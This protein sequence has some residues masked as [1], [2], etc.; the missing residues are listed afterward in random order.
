MCSPSIFTNVLPPTLA[1]LAPPNTLPLRSPE[2]ISTEVLPPRSPAFPPP[3]TLPPILI[4]PCTDTDSN[5]SIRAKLALTRVL[6]IYIGIDIFILS[7][8]FYRRVV[9]ISIRQLIDIGGGDIER[10][11]QFV[12]TLYRKQRS[13]QGIDRCPLT[14]IFVCFVIDIVDTFY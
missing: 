10:Q 14:E 4:W 3:Y 8:Y 9:Q 1:I 12:A 11:R 13:R 7:I 6:I 2:Y 5:T